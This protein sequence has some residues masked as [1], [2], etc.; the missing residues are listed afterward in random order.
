MAECDDRELSSKE[1]NANDLKGPKFVSTFL[2]KI[3][4][5]LPRVVLKQMTNLIFQLNCE[6]RLS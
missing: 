2:L 4:Q 3:S 6:V 1:F 5:L